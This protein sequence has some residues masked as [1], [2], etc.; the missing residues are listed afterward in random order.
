MK[1]LAALA[2]SLTLASAAFAQ[3]KHPHVVDG[4]FTAP[5]GSRTLEQSTVIDAPAETLFRAYL[6]PAEFARWNAPKSWS[7][8]RVG[9]TLEASY[10]P[11][12][13]QGDP[14]NIRHRIVTFLPNRLIVFQN[15]QTPP[16]FPHPEVFQKTYIVLRYLPLA[17]NRTRVSIALTGLGDT[18][19]DRQIEGFFREGNA[20]LLEKM[21][22]VYDSAPVAPA[23][24]PYERALTQSV[25]FAGDKA[26]VWRQVSDEAAIRAQG[27]PF[28]HV[29]LKNGG[30][31]EE[32]F[33]PQPKPG[34]TIRH[35][36]LTYLP[37]DL[38]VLRNEQTGPGL[39]GA[40][41]YKQVV[42]VIDIAPTPTG[43]LR[44][45][46]AHTGYGSGG[47]WDKLYS[48]FESH[49]P[50]FLQQVK[51]TCELKGARRG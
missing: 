26:C 7:E 44:V 25:E 28:A 32:G 14:G 49:N 22:A 15:L 31:M 50:F 42:Q 18:P 17:A 45:T 20:Q 30:L 29:E 9:G 46:L 11:A 6:D 8:L 47:D 34:E 5:D 3:P 19:A 21:K 16:R 33:E 4:S 36:I 37:G 13:K 51:A 10:S 38:M 1:S 12:A 24:A 2:L 40:D 43:A 35:R 27:I 23:P 39:P 41:L 48:F